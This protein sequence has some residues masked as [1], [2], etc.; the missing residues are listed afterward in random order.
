MRLPTI[1]K[2]VLDF[3]TLAIGS[4]Q[5]VIIA[6]RVPLLQWL[7]VSLMMQVHSHTL[8]SSA[9]TIQILLASQS[10]TEEDPGLQF[11]A[12]PVALFTLTSLTPNPGFVNAAAAG[13]GTSDIVRLIARG[14]RSSAG[15]LSATI[16]GE[17]QVTK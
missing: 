2:R 1:P 16:S 7:V 4:T 17:F 3:N 12:T 5:D 6:D 15:A 9:G 11:V 10:W 8:A 13:A 14:S